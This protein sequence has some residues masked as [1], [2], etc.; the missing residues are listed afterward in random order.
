M[1]RAFKGFVLIFGFL[2]IQALFIPAAHAYQVREVSFLSDEAGTGAEIALSG[3][4]DFSFGRLSNPER[5]YVDIKKSSLP[6]E[7]QKE[8]EAFGPL[9]KIL[10]KIRLAQFDPQTV[11]VV[12]ELAGEVGAPNSRVARK[13]RGLVVLFDTAPPQKEGIITVAQIAR[14]KLANVQE[15]SEKKKPEVVPVLPAQR[16]RVVIDA[17]HGG[18]DPGAMSKKGLMEKDLTLKIALELAR[19]LREDPAFQI[20]LTR[21]KDEYLKLEERTQ[22]ANNLKADLFISVHIN[23]SP[24]PATRGIETYFLN[25]T[26]DEE[27]TRVAARENAISVRRMKEAR[28]EL[29]MILASLEIQGK[30]DESL[31]LAHFVQNSLVS[32]INEEY[33]VP[34]LGV[35]QALF[36]VLVGAEMPSIL[37]EVS[38]ISNEQEEKLLRDDDYIKEVSNGIARGVADYLKDIPAQHVARR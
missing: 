4:A 5:L 21:D 14:A 20:Y 2:V 16:W 23:A 29:G 32:S 8:Y 12:F 17:G 19:R 13:D 26:D 31:K 30:R 15:I 27:A 6:A 35:K 22:I 9:K 24:R 33:K 3:P 38:F 10:K 34:D 1:K 28:N 18:H 36:Y 25:F 11:R 37:A 7:V